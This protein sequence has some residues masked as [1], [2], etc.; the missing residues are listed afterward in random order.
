MAMGYRLGLGVAVAVAVAVGE[1]EGECNIA[2]EP[3][4]A[5]V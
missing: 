1:M 5:G 2:S 4:T 3:I